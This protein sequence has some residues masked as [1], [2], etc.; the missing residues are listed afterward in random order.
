MTNN[1]KT[2][3]LGSALTLRHGDAMLS[4]VSQDLLNRINANDA[5][6]L[7]QVGKTALHCNRLGFAQA[8]MRLAAKSGNAE[9]KICL[10]CLEDISTS[11]IDQR[12]QNCFSK[13]S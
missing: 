5:D 12:I 3:S 1:L 4:A 11:S 10:A 13:L 7:L 2:N 6:A 9:A 8:F